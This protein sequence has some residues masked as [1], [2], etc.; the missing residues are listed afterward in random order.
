MSGGEIS[1]NTVTSS[2]R[3]GGGVYVGF[4]TFTMSGGIISGNTASS[5]GGGVIN[6]G[7]F[8]ME[9]GEISGNTSGFNILGGGGGVFLLGDFIKTGGIIYGYSA[10]DTVK[11]NVVKNSNGTV[12][13]N[14]GHAV[15]VYINETTNK[16]KETTAGPGVNL[17]FDGTTNPPTF[18]G[19][20]DY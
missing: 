17:S 9:G 12:Q 11:S 7:T 16:R 3:S 20:W 18:S 15:Y 13:N 8:T 2:S 1:G 14:F 4:G 5:C 6:T 10:G 19:G